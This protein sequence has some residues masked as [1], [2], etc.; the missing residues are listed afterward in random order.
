ML[1]SLAIA[2]LL[3]A[4]ACSESPQA[5]ADLRRMQQVQGP[6]GELRPLPRPPV[7][8]RVVSREP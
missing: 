7:E 8:T 6:T 2:A 4:A 5:A 1:R 3:L